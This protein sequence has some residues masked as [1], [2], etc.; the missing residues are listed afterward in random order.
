MFLLPIFLLASSSFQQLALSFVLGY[1]FDLKERTI[2]T[3]PSRVV[4]D[5]N[6]IDLNAPYAI[7]ALFARSLWTFQYP[8]FAISWLSN[9]KKTKE[10][11]YLIIYGR[12]RTIEGLRIHRTT[13]Q[14]CHFQQQRRSAFNRMVFE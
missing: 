7:I 5:G 13:T 9:K 1:D 6:V 8:E 4:M 12:R 3:S 10:E 2:S 11:N 14:V